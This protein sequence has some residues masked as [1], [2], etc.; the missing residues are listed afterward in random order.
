MGSLFT[1]VHSGQM[2]FVAKALLSCKALKSCVCLHSG[3]SRDLCSSLRTVA[4]GKF[5]LSQYVPGGIGLNGPTSYTQRDT[6]NCKGQFTY[7]AHEEQCRFRQ[8]G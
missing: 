4:E 6:V 5:L 1:V 7:S 2:C 8:I 3:C